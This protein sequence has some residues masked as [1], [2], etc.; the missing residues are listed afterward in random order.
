MAAEYLLCIDDTDNLESPG[1]GHLLQDICDL[2]KARGLAI[3]ERISRHQLFRHPKVPFTSH[4]SSMCTLLREVDQADQVI[5]TVETELTARAAVGS[6]PGVC[7][8]RRDGIL[9]PELLAEY[10]LRAKGEILTKAEAYRTAQACGLYLNELGGTG[11]GVIGAVAGIALRH[12]G[13]DGRFRG[14]I[15]F[16]AVADPCRGADFLRLPEVDCLCCA[17]TLE[18]L[19]PEVAVTWLPEFKTVLLKNRSVL[20]LKRNGAGWRVMNREE[21]KEQFA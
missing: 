12:G 1:S 14:R 6:D 20:P 8:V 9:A 2:L 11:D 18:S 3:A 15:P 4:N 7:C 16:F 5:Q 17:D 13:A 19:S 21:L 10:G